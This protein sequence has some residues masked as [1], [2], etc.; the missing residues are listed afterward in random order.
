MRRTPDGPR[1]RTRAMSSVLSGE[2][3]VGS[4]SLL[5]LIAQ[6]GEVGADVVAG[7]FWIDGEAKGDGGFG[8][9]RMPCRE[10]HRRRAQ[11]G[12]K[13]VATPHAQHSSTNN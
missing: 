5:C 11:R 12:L 3:K 6:A 2:K 1:R 10:T 4:P 7:G 13:E 8:L 9:V